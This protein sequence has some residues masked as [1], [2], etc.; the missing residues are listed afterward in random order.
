MVRR[1]AHPDLAAAVRA[2]LVHARSFEEVWYSGEG[3]DSG[4]GIDLADGVPVG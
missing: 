1:R 4:E 2:A 3:S